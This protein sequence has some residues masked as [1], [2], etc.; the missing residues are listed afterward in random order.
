M[1]AAPTL[2][3]A[4]ETLGYFDELT[5]GKRYDI[6]ATTI[7]YESALEF[8]HAFDPLSF[9]IDEEAAKG[10]MFGGLIVSGLLT[11]SVIHALSVRGGFLSETSVVCGAGFDELRF[12]RPVRPG[13]ILSV[14]AEVQELR[15][16]RREGGPGVARLMYWVKN[17][18]D[19][20]VMTFIDNHVIRL[21][22]NRLDEQNAGGRDLDTASPLQS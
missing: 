7:S 5:V 3:A 12:L 16:P 13:D 21:R 8:A 11:I 14:T 9:H 20:V 17:H 22:P 2:N 18:D 6:G 15:P 19:I 1:I 10:S 4:S